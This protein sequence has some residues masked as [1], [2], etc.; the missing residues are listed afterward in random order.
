[1]PYPTSKRVMWLGQV[2]SVPYRERVEVT[3]KAGCGWLSTSPMD[4]DNIR[5]TGLSDA[6]IRGI[7]SDSGI[8]LSYLDPMT[9]WVPDGLPINEDP[10]ILPYLDRSPDDYFRIAEALQVDRI[11]LIGCFP[12]G[13]YTLDELTQYYAAMCDRAAASGLKC[14]IEAM[15]LWGLRTVDEAWAIVKGAGRS[16]S[17]IIFDT[18]HYVRAGRNDALLREIPV[19]TFDTIQIADGPLTCPPGRDNVHDCLFHRVPI[20]KGQIPNLEIL[21]ILRDAGHI[22]SVGPE[23]FSS[24]HDRLNGDEIIGR[25]MP[26]FDA[27]LA[28]LESSARSPQS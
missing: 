15:P 22:E 14:L 12:V 11:H 9:S 4:Y 1:M 27:I 13:R 25:V 16:N 6:D 8:R 24:D 2:R 5:A 19:G 18:W 10:A 21:K 20:G 17:G 26:G 3:A 28:E 7:A 23:I